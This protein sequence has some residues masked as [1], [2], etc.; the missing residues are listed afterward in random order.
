MRVRGLWAGWRGGGLW[1]RQVD[2]G[3]TVSEALARLAG[4]A[5]DLVPH[6]AARV[7]AAHRPLLQALLQPG[8]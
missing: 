8:A 3:R 4:S 5:P 7:P 2:V 6:L 1:V